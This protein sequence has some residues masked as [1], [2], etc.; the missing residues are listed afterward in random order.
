MAQVA[1]CSTAIFS[2]YPPET[3]AV[4]MMA[5]EKIWPD[6]P[7]SFKPQ[8]LQRVQPRRFQKE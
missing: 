1:G 8:G 3:L 5:N 2:S 6:R 7:N 4:H